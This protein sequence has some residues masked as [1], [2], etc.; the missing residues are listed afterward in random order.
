MVELTLTLRFS[1]G[2]L[3]SEQLEL[4]LPTLQKCWDL[5]STPTL[6]WLYF[7]LFLLP[8]RYWESAGTV[9]VRDWQALQQL[10][11]D[12]P[13]AVRLEAVGTQFYAVLRH[14]QRVLLQGGSEEVRC[15]QEAWAALT[16]E[17]EP[18]MG[19]LP[20]G[21]RAYQERAILAEL[22]PMITA[23]LQQAVEESEWVSRVQAQVAI[24]EFQTEIAAL[25]RF[26]AL[27]QELAR[28]GLVHYTDDLELAVTLCDLSWTTLV[29]TR[30]DR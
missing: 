4:S 16:S 25:P 3:R 1:G 9:S 17:F 14:L 19:A 5:R 27:V 11:L 6:L 20:A 24:A 2:G 7:A 12:P 15:E 28:R 13:S 21:P 30:T 18:R 22:Q 26:I 10:L 8:R 23:S 29:Q